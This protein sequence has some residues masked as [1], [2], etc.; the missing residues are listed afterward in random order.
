MQKAGTGRKQ[1]SVKP[2]IYLNPCFPLT[3]FFPNPTNRE[4]HQTTNSQYPHWK[5][6]I[7]YTVQLQQYSCSFKPLFE[8]CHY[9]NRSVMP[10]T[11]SG[12]LHLNSFL[13]FSTKPSTEPQLIQDSV[14]RGGGGSVLFGFFY[15][16]LPC[17]FQ[18]VLSPTNAI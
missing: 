17:L 13:V 1:Q 6:G 11:L 14:R 15:P 7:F 16:S 2:I 3:T 9:G 8:Q 12:L 18:K 4:K 10:C 5:I